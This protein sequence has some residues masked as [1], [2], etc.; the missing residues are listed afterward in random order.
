M[1]NKFIPANTPLSSQKLQAMVSAK[2]DRNRVINDGA[3]EG[4][5]KTDKFATTQF[6]SP[7]ERQA[8]TGA[9]VPI[10]YG[11]ILTKGVVIDTNNSDNDPA[12]SV[13]FKN[14]RFIMSEGPTG[15]IHVGSTSKKAHVII[16]EN[17]LENPDTNEIEL[18]GVEVKDVNTPVAA[19]WPTSTLVSSK[20]KDIDISPYK[21]GTTDLN[22]TL[23]RKNH[24][25]GLADVS[26]SPANGSIL[27]Y[28]SSVKKFEIV[29]LATELNNLP[30]LVVSDS[31]IGTEIETEKW[32]LPASVTTFAVTWDDDTRA[33]D[34]PYRWWKNDFSA[35]TG[36]PVDLDL[37]NKGIDQDTDGTKECMILNGFPR[38]DI[39]MYE[40]VTY[41]FNVTGIP[42]GY[43]F[44]I[45]TGDS[46]TNLL[47]TTPTSGT[48][49]FRPTSSTQR[50][51]YYGSATGNHISDGGRILVR[52]A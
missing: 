2:V 7:A 5:V 1:A 52:S 6:Y 25:A 16:N 10:V 31:D 50:I 47:S 46:A 37:S 11:T 27:R 45:R 29:D 30:I 23:L 4:S 3:V 41:T 20:S 33:D 43:G 42:A 8:T 17:S 14:I 32:I 18:A 48:E 40:D 9:K 26:G 13:N 24:L 34:S 28:N 15:G 49:T 35:G 19:S 44:G 36:S 21:A 39:V 22:A 38:P 51:L 12:D